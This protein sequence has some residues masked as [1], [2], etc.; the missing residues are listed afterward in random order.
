MI[1]TMS[2]SIDDKDLNRYITCVSTI[3]N[4][5]I[6]FCSDWK[7]SLNKKLEFMTKSL[8]NPLSI[9]YPLGEHIYQ[10]SGSTPLTIT[11]LP[12]NSF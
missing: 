3:N 2:F 6:K 12:R 8:E 10:I 7:Q 1:E 4:E 5:Y 11:C 9:M